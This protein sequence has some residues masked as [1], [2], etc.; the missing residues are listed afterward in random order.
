MKVRKESEIYTTKSNVSKF[1][2]VFKENNLIAF[3]DL[4]LSMNGEY[5]T[6]KVTFQIISGSTNSNFPDRD[7]AFAWK[8][9][10]NKYQVTSAPSWLMLKKKF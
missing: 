8:K 7:A 10:C 5:K 4:T 3:K 6:G 9:L 1:K 2:E